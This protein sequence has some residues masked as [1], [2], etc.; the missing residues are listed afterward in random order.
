VEIALDQN[1]M[2]DNDVHGYCNFHGHS[3]GL[4][5]LAQIQQKYRDLLG[6]EA[7]TTTST[8]PDLLGIFDSRSSFCGSGNRIRPLGL[9]P[10]EVARELVDGA[11]ENIC[12]LSRVVHR[13]TFDTLFDRMYDLGAGDMEREEPRFLSLLYAVMAVGSFASSRYKRRRNEATP[14]A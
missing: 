5:F 6:P 10:R 12:P 7:K 4:A 3:S 11:L 14:T 2:L 9:P 1:G 13:P 8:V